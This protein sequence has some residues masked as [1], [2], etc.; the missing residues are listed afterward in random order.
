MLN[1]AINWFRGIL[2]LIGLV[3]IFGVG[4]YFFVQLV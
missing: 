1:E 2:V 4:I 3:I